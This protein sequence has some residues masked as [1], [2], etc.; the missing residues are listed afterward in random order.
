MFDGSSEKM[1]GFVTAYKLYIRMKMR[2]VVVEEQI[3]WILLYI[4]EE[5]ANI[6]KENIL[7]DLEGGLLEYETAEEF[8]ADIKKEFGRGDKEI[9]KIAELKR[10]EQGGKTMEKFV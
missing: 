8:L 7:E 3:Q 5:L 4:Q 10:L 6:Q 2:R 1:S 9:V